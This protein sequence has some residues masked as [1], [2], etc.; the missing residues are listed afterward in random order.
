MKSLF[1][2]LAFALLDLNAPTAPAPH[3]EMYI[4]NLPCEVR[5]YVDDNGTPEKADDFV[6]DFEI[7]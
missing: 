1:I 6:F 5:L 4:V 3:S 7:R 2:A